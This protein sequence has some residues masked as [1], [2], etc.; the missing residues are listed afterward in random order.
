LTNESIYDNIIHKGEKMTKRK[1]VGIY[2]DVNVWKAFNKEIKPTGQSVS[3]VLETVMRVATSKDAE[4][5]YN[6]FDSIFQM[7]KKYGNIP[8]DK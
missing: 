2:I 1:R 5:I 7:G 6:I 3:R 8:D 4:P